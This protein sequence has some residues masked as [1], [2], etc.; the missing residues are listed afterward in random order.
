MPQ[1]NHANMNLHC[2]SKLCHII[3]FSP[4]NKYIYYNPENKS[5]SSN[6]KTIT[7]PVGDEKKTKQNHWELYGREKGQRE[8]WREFL[9]GYVVT[10]EKTRVLI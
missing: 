9:Q 6:K 4:R 7:F 3:I 5:E 8:G 2:K 10:R 1:I